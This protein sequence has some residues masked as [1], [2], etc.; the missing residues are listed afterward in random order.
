MTLTFTLVDNLT[1]IESLT[2]S[3]N[4]ISLIFEDAV[5]ATADLPEIYKII[6]T[7]DMAFARTDYP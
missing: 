3:G 1:I 7:G 4:N 5:T 2:R 6:R